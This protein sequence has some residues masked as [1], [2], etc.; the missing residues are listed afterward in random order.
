M[1]DVERARDFYGRVL[2]LELLPRPDF[3]FP[4]ACYPLAVEDAD[5][6]HRHLTGTGY[7]FR[8]VV[9]GPTGMRQ[10]FVCDPDGNM[11]EFLGPSRHAAAARFA[12]P[13]PVE[14]R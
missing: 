5:E 1:T 4:G 6:V 10:M 9:Q 12:P 14:R 2:G 8:D 3:D 13:A 7:P 11:V